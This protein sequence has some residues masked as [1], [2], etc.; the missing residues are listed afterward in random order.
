[1]QTHMNEC[2]NDNVHVSGVTTLL[3]QLS[4]QLGTR[5]FGKNKKFEINKSTE[6]KRICVYQ[7]ESKQPPHKNLVFRQQNTKI[8]LKLPTL[9]EELAK[10]IKIWS[11]FHIFVKTTSKISSILREKR[12]I[13]YPNFLGTRR[14][15]LVIFGQV[16]AEFSLRHCRLDSTR[17]L[18][19]LMEIF[20]KS[21]FE[22]KVV[23]KCNFEHRLSIFGV[24]EC[25]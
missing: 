22:K 21:N 25:H 12:L 14:S 6:R 7:H 16:H 19:S 18:A 5:R 23:P 10:T 2:M 20:K 11:Q 9:V 17:R 4:W 13:F 3:S 24:G 8:F 1:M 15:F